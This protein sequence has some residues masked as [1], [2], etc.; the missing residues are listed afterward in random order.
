MTDTSR[1]QDTQQVV[2]RPA[3]AEDKDAVFAFC[4]QTWPGGDY[5]PYVW[6]DWL[7]DAR[8]ALLV[9]AA[10]DRPVGI[11]HVKMLA[12]DEAWLEGIRVDPRERRHGIGRVLLSRALVAS[13]ERGA[14]V[15]RLITDFDNYAAHG[16][17][18]AFGFTRVAEVK[19]YRAEALSPASLMALA[20]D[21]PAEPVDEDLSALAPAPL[22][23]ASEDA[24]LEGARL[25]APGPEE[26]ERL[27]SW[28]VQ[29]NLS[30]LNG[31]LEF[32]NWTA[33]ALTEPALRRYLA[34][35]RVLLLEE[36]QTILALATI[37]DVPAREERPASLE[38]TY[39]DGLSDAIGRLA[40]VLR[41]VAA[42]RGQ[43]Q[44]VLWLPNLLILHDAMDGAGYVGEDNPLLVYSRTL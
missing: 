44:V 28:L 10:G 25:T 30:P 19:R 8:G 23:P 32:A 27:W 29:S 35:E 16:L 24:V 21:Q 15:A 40:L 17:F 7:R 37:R 43:S 34:E 38:V 3:R 6:D 13:R 12:Q 11:A 14:T 41:E 31:G 26:F 5:I 9:A 22:P 39:V 36:W 1:S 4:A 2:V 18:A 20:Q 33:R 42:E